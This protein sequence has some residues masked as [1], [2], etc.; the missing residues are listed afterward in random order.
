MLIGM[1]RIVFEKIGDAVQDPQPTFET[2]GAAD[3]RFR[4]VATTL[5]DGDTETIDYIVQYDDGCEYRGSFD[6]QWWHRDKSN[7]LGDHI[8]HFLQVLGGFKN[9]RA[10]RREWYRAQ[11]ASIEEKNPGAK[12]RCRLWL[13]TY[14]IG[15]TA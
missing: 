9:Q 4:D 12:A 15:E 1:T 10:N 8:R 13:E 3:D 2:W 14:E 5:Q 7:L 6:V 11:L